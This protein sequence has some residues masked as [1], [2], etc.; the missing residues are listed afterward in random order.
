MQTW[1]FKRLDNED[2]SYPQEGRSPVDALVRFG[3]TCLPGGGFIG[4]VRCVEDGV[5]YHTTA[6]GRHHTI[7]IV[8]PDVQFDTTTLPELP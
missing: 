3:A 1:T 4:P 7:T 6:D 8:R 2:L 5:I